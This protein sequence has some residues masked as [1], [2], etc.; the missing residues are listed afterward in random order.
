MTA[1]LFQN[2]A[3]WIKLLRVK[4]W[5]KN[6][7][8]VVPLFF[9]GKL[10]NPDL[11]ILAWGG[12]A[13]FSLMASAVYIVND[14]IDLP[15]D[16]Q[17]P[18]KSARPI[19]SGAI[20]PNTAHYAV[21]LLFLSSLALSFVISVEATVFLLFY[22][23]LNVVYSL[24]F[25]NLPVVD[26]AIIAAGF[27]LRVLYGGSCCGIPISLWLYLTVFSF[28]VYLAFGKRRGELLNVG[29]SGR[30]SLEKYNMSFLD[31]SMN[32]FLTCGFVFISLW[33]FEKAQLTSS[34]VSLESLVLVL[35]VPL[36]MLV[37]LRYNYI[38]EKPGNDGDP[39]TVFF[40]DM[41]LVTLVI[42]CVFSMFCSIYLFR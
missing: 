9:S 17:H 6:L 37:F 12:V 29:T 10:F 14:L 25:K 4:H 20:Q 24:K 22:A 3:N 38:L 11:E 23:M 19:A 15:R 34:S 26:V 39:V 18:T 2:V 42:F 7:L 8:I 35:G 13:A 40:K 30:V 33:A 21:T 1:P 5:F 31:S 27:I 16:K 41:P 32:I 28:S 36:T